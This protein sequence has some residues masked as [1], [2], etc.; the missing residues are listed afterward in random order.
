MDNRWDC[1]VACLQGWSVDQL[2]LPRAWGAVYKLPASH[3]CRLLSSAYQHRVSSELSSETWLCLYISASTWA[4]PSLLPGPGPFCYG[5]FATHLQLLPSFWQ[6]IFIE[7][8][9]SWR[10]YSAPFFR[11]QLVLRECSAI[12]Y[13]FLSPTVTGLRHLLVKLQAARAQWHALLGVGT[14]Q[15]VIVDHDLGPH[16]SVSLHLLSSAQLWSLLSTN[17]DNLLLCGRPQVVGKGAL[18]SSLWQPGT[19]CTSQAS[20]QGS[21]LCLRVYH[22]AGRWRDCPESD[23][24][25]IKCKWEGGWMA[26]RNRLPFFLQP[27]HLVFLIKI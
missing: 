24:P 3:L 23:Q 19:P 18:E 12:Y 17:V 4:F 13:A 21:L 15:S 9:L 6:K 8:P 27:L 20:F 22:Q 25:Q 7:P 26:W 16:H 14:Q 2:G 11:Y 5:L 10:T 1:L